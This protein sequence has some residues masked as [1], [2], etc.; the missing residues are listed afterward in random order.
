MKRGLPESQDREQQTVSV[1]R[2]GEDHSQKKT[3]PGK[4]GG[5]NW[6]RDVWARLLATSLVLAG[7]KLF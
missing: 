1:P 5:R 7:T 2:S 6:D 3:P 4:S